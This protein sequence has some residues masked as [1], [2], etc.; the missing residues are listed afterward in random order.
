MVAL[1]QGR[2]QQQQQRQ[3]EENAQQAGMV[4]GAGSLADYFPCIW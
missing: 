4:A 1:Q 3:G 2:Q